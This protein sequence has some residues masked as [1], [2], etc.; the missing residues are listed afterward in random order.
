GGRRGGRRR[1]V[2]GGGGGGVAG[3]G[4]GGVAGGH[5]QPRRDLRGLRQRAGGRGPAAAV[6]LAGLGAGRLQFGAEQRGERRPGVA[7]TGRED[8]AQHAGELFGHVARRGAAAA[9]IGGGGPAQQPVER[10]LL[11]EQRHRVWARERVLV[12]AGVPGEVEGEHGQGTPDR[13]QVR[14]RGG[15]VARDLRCLVADRSVDRAVLV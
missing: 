9:G 3:G 2:G 12:G 7:V 4:V 10:L 8:L 15:S 5:R 6:H 1:R 13:V 11:R 14:R